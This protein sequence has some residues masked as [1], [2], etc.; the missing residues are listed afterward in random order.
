MRDLA[1]QRRCAPCP[2]P[3][4]PKPLRR[5]SSAQ[6]FRDFPGGA[7]QLK[8]PHT[9]PKSCMRRIHKSAV[10]LT[11]SKWIPLR[12]PT[13][14]LPDNGAEPVA[15]YSTSV[16]PSGVHSSDSSI[17]HSHHQRLSVILKEDYFSPS[18]V[19]SLLSGT[20]SLHSGPVKEFRDAWAWLV[21]LLQILTAAEV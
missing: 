12:I 3:G 1:V 8:K 21:F 16:A 4:N 14:A 10:P 7:K 5:A 18:S 13:Y 11:L 9:R 19:C 17:P 6:H 20:L 2:P 15:S